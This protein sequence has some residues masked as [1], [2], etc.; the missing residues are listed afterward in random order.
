MF[1]RLV[2]TYV[3]RPLSRLLLRTLPLD[4]PWARYSSPV[5]LGHYG[6]GARQEFRWYFDGES[7]VTVGTLDEIQ[8]WLL[9]C[10][11]AR[12]PEL[13]HEADYWQ[14]P[15]TFEHLRRGDCED[16]TL[17]AWRKMARLGYDAEFVAGRCTQPGC[18][19]TGHTWILF[20]QDGIT[21]LFDPVIRKKDLMIRPLDDV[22]YEYA[23]E[24]SVDR[25]FN[26]YVYAGHFLH[27]QAPDRAFLTRPVT[28]LVHV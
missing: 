6:I 15:C 21:Y 17:W 27:R 10:T 28:P 16:F 5:P 14:H 1:L 8:T 22:R 18:D 13:F 20:Q 26:R 7:A 4:D 24:V 3:S 9:G 12:D 19:A 23:P 2:R 11:Y 25:H